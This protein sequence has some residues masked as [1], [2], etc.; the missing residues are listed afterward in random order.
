M[1]PKNIF[2]FSSMLGQLKNGVQKNNLFLHHFMTQNNYIYNINCYN[3]IFL[4][5]NLLY[6]SNFFS[7][8]KTINIGGDHSMAISTIASSLN[9]YDN[10][11]VIW[12]DAHPDINTFDSSKTKNYHG[13][14]LS[15]LTGLD[16]DK[17][18]S[19][20]D[21]ILPMKNILYIG[22][23]D[24]D[25]FEEKVILNNNI[26]YICVN[27]MRK[28]FKKCLVKINEFV[29]KSPIHV[30]FDID[31]IDP[32]F[33]PCTGTPVKNG[34]NVKEATKLVNNLNKHNIVNM[35]IAELNLEIGTINDKM[36]SLSNFFK[37]FK[38]ILLI[39]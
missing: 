13:M 24:I 6:K 19:F 26:N 31:A 34:L 7:K 30:S 21:K 32:K 8:G 14:P 20:I 4:N 12:I 2:F 11:K 28:D 5:L 3:N 37:I 27:D 15:F 33:I 22:I 23:R 29:D 17:K 25:K 38:K 18:F 35:D 10:L 9:R 16:Y 1:Y 39:K 36:K